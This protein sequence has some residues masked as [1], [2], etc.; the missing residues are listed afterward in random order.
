MNK[1]DDCKIYMTNK[2]GDPNQLNQLPNEPITYFMIPVSWLCLVLRA[3][4]LIVN[5]SGCNRIDLR[6]S[7]IE[8]GRG[9]GGGPIAGFGAGLHHLLSVVLRF[10]QNNVALGQ[11]DAGQQAEAGSQ[12][13][14]NLD[15]DHE[16]ATCAEVRWD[17]GD[18]HDEEDE[19][20][21][22]HRLGLTGKQSKK[23]A[24]SR[25]RFFTQNG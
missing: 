17:K 25:E 13:G 15:S 5:S 2:T 11:K 23:D 9:P 19:H 3:A 18:P 12:D 1:H 8:G 6:N 20:A 4:P 22:G 10:D 16:L 24:A 14:K 7:C 21:E